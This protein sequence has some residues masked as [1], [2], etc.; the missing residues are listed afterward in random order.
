MKKVNK[1]KYLFLGLIT[2]LS[3]VCIGNAAFWNTEIKNVSGTPTTN[4]DSYIPVCYAGNKTY[5]SI[6]AAIADVGTPST[7]TTIYV[8]PNLTNYDG[9]RRTV[10]INDDITINNLVT[11]CL[12]YSG[13]KYDAGNSWNSEKNSDGNTFSI[14]RSFADSN[15]ETKPIY[16]SNGN[17][18]EYTNMTIAAARTTLVKLLDDKKITIESGG[19]LQIGGQCGYQNQYNVSG[20]VNGNY[21]EL[22][23]GNGSQIIAESGATID[24][25]GYIKQDK[26]NEET[27][28]DDLEMVILESGATL[29]TMLTIYD[30]KGGTRT[31]GKATE[32]GKGGLNAKGIMPFY[33]YDITNIQSKIKVHFGA[34]LFVSGRILVGGSAFNR[35]L[36]F[37]GIESDANA[38]FQMKNGYSYYEYIPSD[39]E[40]EVTDIHG[41]TKIDIFGSCAFNKIVLSVSMLG[42]E[43]NIDT[44]NF[45][46]AIHQKLRISLNKMPDS[47]AEVNFEVKNSLKLLPGSEIIINEGVNLKISSTK[48][49]IIYPTF[50]YANGAKLDSRWGDY[51]EPIFICNGSVYSDNGG[52]VVG[53]VA[54]TSNTGILD[55]RNFSVTSSKTNEAPGDNFYSAH[56]GS[57]PESV[58]LTGPTA[59]SI[60]TNLE[61]NK[62]LSAGNYWFIDEN[63]SSENMISI[64]YSDYADYLSFDSAS[65]KYSTD[66]GGSGQITLTANIDNSMYD[67]D[68]YKWIISDSNNGYFEEGTENAEQTTLYINANSNTD[69]N[70]EFTIS[71]EVTFNGGLP[72]PAEATSYT[73]VRTKKSSSSGCLTPSTLITMADGSKKEVK[74]IVAGD[75]LLVFNHETGQ[76]DSSPVIFNDFEPMNNVN[77]INLNFS[78]GKQVGV[79]Y[80]HGFF[81]LTLGKYVYIDEN[82]AMD[83]IGHEFYVVDGGS[84]RLNSVN[85][86]E[87][88]TECYSPVTAYHLNYFT[89]DMLS[90]PGGIEGFFNIFEYGKDLKYIDES[91]QA[92]IALY[93]LF[94]YEDFKDI[95]PYE[96]YCMFPASYLKVSIGKGYITWED[97][98]ALIDRYQKFWI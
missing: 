6:E 58:S 93:G 92:D 69:N 25:Y 1:I 53:K 7:A 4:S 19:K 78:N 75:E 88:Y 34:K 43:V 22:R 23:L 59:D 32:F 28:P 86:V 95:L 65:N 77:V 97:I 16:D 72:N 51:D 33:L 55:A 67:V 52:Y 76:L 27:D 36:Q 68:K 26:E 14:Y 61:K 94:T 5:R 10:Y 12:P 98:L 45:D 64:S 49:I 38:L 90:M 2:T 47:D 85:I 60:N 30:F 39:P 54:T 35:Q 37:F 3:F 82:S 40:R 63:A 46:F 84:A 41:T 57:Y 13:T 91:K 20:C 70:I 15:T 87:E 11:L 81:D 80:E 62:Y 8:Y 9:S 21:A 74:N 29:N 24:C 71:L 31:I 83:Y 66:A 96:V 42:F 79:I 73:F 48:R 18:S 89:E 44:S 17:I 56:S 50:K